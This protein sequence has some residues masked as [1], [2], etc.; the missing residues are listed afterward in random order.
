MSLPVLTHLLPQ[1]VNP[2]VH[3]GLQPMFAPPEPLAVALPPVPLAPV[4]LAPVPL[5]PPPPL[6]PELVCALLLAPPAPT[7]LA[8][9]P[10]VLPFGPAA[11]TLDWPPLPAVWLMKVLPQARK[12]RT[13]AAMLLTFMRIDIRLI[14]SGEPHHS[15]PS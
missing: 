14:S 2:C 8:P 11:P 4:P 9:S 7:L 15:L 6:A 5:A 10:V 3:G 12:S 1:Q 13:A